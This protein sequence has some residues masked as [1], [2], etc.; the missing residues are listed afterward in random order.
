MRR[1]SI[2]IAAVRTVA[3]PLVMATACASSP[4]EP[5]WQPVVL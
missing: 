2:T 3:L 1:F 4:T 5:Q